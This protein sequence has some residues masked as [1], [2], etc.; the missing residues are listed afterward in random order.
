[1]CRSEEAAYGGAWTHELKLDGFRLQ[2][3][4]TDRLTLLGTG[5]APN[6]PIHADR[7]GTGE[8]E[9][10]TEETVIDGEVG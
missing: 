8:T 7:I 10:L 3:V 1:M 9:R 2:A 4:R 6:E 5:E